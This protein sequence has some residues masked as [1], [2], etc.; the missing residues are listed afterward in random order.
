VQN[1][2]VA[3]EDPPTEAE[4]IDPE[5][6]QPQKGIRY[7]EAKRSNPAVGNPKGVLHV[8]EMVQF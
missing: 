3:F 2:D 7:R 1:P 4:V 8:I 5:T 6:G